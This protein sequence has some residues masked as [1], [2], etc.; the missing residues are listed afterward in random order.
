MIES[1]HH[2]ARKKGYCSE[3]TI[4]MLI[5]V[6]YTTNYMIIKFYKAHAALV[7]NQ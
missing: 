3:I 2:G 7:P 6:Y 1:P 5:M 4:L